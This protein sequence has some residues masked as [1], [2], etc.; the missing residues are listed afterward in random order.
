MKIYI[1]NTDYKEWGLLNN[2]L[3]NVP[4]NLSQWTAVAEESPHK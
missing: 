4:T 1:Y 2:E 3:E